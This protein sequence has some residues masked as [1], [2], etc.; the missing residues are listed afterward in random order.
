[1]AYN[2]IKPQKTNFPSIINKNRKNKIKS[3]TRKESVV[4]TLTILITLFGFLIRTWR[5]IREGMPITFDG[6]YYLRY[7]KRDFFQGWIDFSKMTRD[8]P[9]FTILM[10]FATHMLGLDVVPMMWVIYIFP[11]IVC[12]IQLVIYYVLARRLTKSRMTGLM[13]MFIMSFLGMIVYRNQNIAPETIVLGLVPYVVYFI[14]RYLENKDY[15][16]LISGVLITFGITLVHHLTT[17]IV[18]AIWHILILYEIMYRHIK[19]RPFTKRDI[20]INFLTLVII[21]AFVV[22][23]WTFGLKGFPINFIGESILTLF[24]E[25]EPIAPTVLMIVTV[26]VINVLAASVFYYNFNKKRVNQVIIAFGVFGVIAM[27][28][29]AM[30]YGASS[31]DQSLLSGA[32]MGTHALVLAPLGAIGLISLEKNNLIRSRMIRGWFYCIILIISITAIFPLM[33]SLLGRLALYIAG[34][35]V[36]LSAIAIIKIIEKINLRKFKALALIGLTLFATSTLSYSHP[37]P[38]NNWNTQEIYWDAEFATVDFLIMYSQPP[39]NTIWKSN[40]DIIVD[41]DFRFAAI[42]EGISGMQTTIEHGRSWLMTILF[43]NETYLPVFVNSTSPLSV[44]SMINYVVI[45]DVI[46]NNGFMTGWAAYGEDNID[47]IKKLPDISLLL[48]INPHINRIYDT[49][50]TILLSPRFI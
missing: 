32:L 17:F 43:L 34:V 11:Q 15:R 48:P 23:F 49:K 27:F 8:P 26:F 37:T 35:G 46:K 25:G 13:T 1:M 6:Y 28:I 29:I 16:F 42:V 50:I 47:W 3:Y 44:N 21:N 40:L 19:S 30:F 9:G 18:V 14:L 38:E 20:F 31:P 24:P 39:N 45:N 36:A 33:S 7:L 4:I 41:C 12:T 5:L 22:L 10:I 2:G